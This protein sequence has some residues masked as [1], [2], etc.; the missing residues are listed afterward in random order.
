MP[1]TAPLSPAQLVLLAR[2]REIDA[3]RRLQA[4][5]DLVEALGQL[6]HAL[7]RERGA[8]SIFLASLGVHFADVRRVTVEAVHESQ[9][10]LRLLVESQAEPSQGASA[11]ILSLLA[12]VLLDLDALPALRARIEGQ[13]LSAHDAVAAYS[14]LIAGQVELISHV[15]D[16]TLVPGVSPL[17]VAFLHLVQGKEA[18]GQERAVGALMYASG[19]CDDEHQQRVIH[20]IDSQERSLQVFAEFADPA[21]RARWEAHQ[22]SAGTARLERL[23]RTLCAARPGMALDSQLSEAWFDVSSARIDMLWDLEVALTQRL[24]EACAEQIRQAEKELQDSEGLLQ[25]LRD[26][27]PPHA[28]AVEHFFD[29]ASQPEAAP[30]LAVDPASAT[31]LQLL[32]SQST[33]LAGMEAELD[34]AR[35]ALHERKVI[36]RA[37]G[38]LMSRLRMSEEAAFRALQKTSMDQ[39]RRLL[40]VAE[41]TLSLP[42]QTFE[43]LAAQQG[44]KLRR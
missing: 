28:H 43:Q 23:R 40:D 35:R 21:L 36:E 9:Q 27:P 13:A 39:N 15:A 17:L 11:R 8:S 6:M 41:A 22:L 33:R 7:Q 32:Q 4:R 24:R 16:A 34:A 37:K 1:D 30:A 38:V 2:Q 3:M 25:R 29:M 18:A 26:N 14:T 12:W 5:A 20:L 10:R 31:L 19:L 44:D 42:D